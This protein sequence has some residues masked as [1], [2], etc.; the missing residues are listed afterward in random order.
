MAV[1]IS[2]YDVYADLSNAH[3]RINSEVQWLSDL[4][5]YKTEELERMPVG[6]FNQK[7]VYYTRKLQKEKEYYDR[8]KNGGS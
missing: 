4:S 7:L 6:E 8:V 3:D 5:K 2:A 1:S